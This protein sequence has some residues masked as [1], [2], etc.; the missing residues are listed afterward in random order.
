MP[1]VNGGVRADEA[2]S[3]GSDQGVAQ[4]RDRMLIGVGYSEAD[5]GFGH[6]VNEKRARLAAAARQIRP[7]V[8]APVG[9]SQRNGPR[10][11]GPARPREAREGNY[12]SE[13]R[14]NEAGLRI[15]NRKQEPTNP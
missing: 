15:P 6:V 13:A 5:E 7:D 12:N 8:Q 10:Q 11:Q 3:A 2:I 1:H 4:W 14:K 9:S